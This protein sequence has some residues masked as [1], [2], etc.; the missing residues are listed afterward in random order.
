MAKIETTYAFQN[1]TIFLWAEDTM[2]GVP[3]LTMTF[4]VSS[5]LCHLPI[6]EQTIIVRNRL[7]TPQI[8]V[9]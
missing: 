3:V 7:K 2:I 1:R 4:S 5:A 6:F 9:Y 8:P